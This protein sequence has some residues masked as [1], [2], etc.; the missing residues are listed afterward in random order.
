MK[1]NQLI[2]I[3]AIIS[4][5]AFSTINIAQAATQKTD[6]EKGMEAYMK[7]DFKTAFKYLSKAEKKGDLDAKFMLAGL[8]LYGDGVKQ[9]INKGQSLLVEGCVERH[10]Q[11]CK[12]LVQIL[13]TQCNEGNNGACTFLKKLIK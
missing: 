1:F 12:V 4:C 2:K 7:Q 13:E 8:Y 5:V 11:S 9:N 3:A 6:T 10:I